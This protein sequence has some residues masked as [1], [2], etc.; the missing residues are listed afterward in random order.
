M[1]ISPTG[2]KNI[3]STECSCFKIRWETDPPSIQRT[4]NHVSVDTEGVRRGTIV[5]ELPYYVLSPSLASDFNIIC[6]SETLEGII[7]KHMP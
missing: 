7:A 3:A 4:V 6:T 5:V 2:Y 1:Q